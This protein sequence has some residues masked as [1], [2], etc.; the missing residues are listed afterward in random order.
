MFTHQHARYAVAFLAVLV[1][2]FVTEEQGRSIARIIEAAC[3]GEQ[4]S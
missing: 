4:R 3:T 1:S 2:P